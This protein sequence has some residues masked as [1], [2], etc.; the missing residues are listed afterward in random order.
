MKYKIRVLL[1]SSSAQTFFHLIPD[2]KRSRIIRMFLQKEYQLP[3]DLKEFIVT[4][5]EQTGFDVFLNESSLNQLDSLVEE[6]RRF[7][8]TEEPGYKVTRS[9]IMQHVISQINK[10]HQEHPIENTKGA[11]KP[12]YLPRSH[13]EML[14]NMIS[15]REITHTIEDFIYEEYK[16]P[17]VTT[18]MLKAKQDEEMVITQ[19]KLEEKAI[20]LLDKFAKEK[21][22]TRSH[23]LRDVVDQLIKKM[24]S[25]HGDVSEMVYSRLDDIVTELKGFANEDQ[26]LEAIQQYQ[27]EKKK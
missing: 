19:L 26:I 22:V 6:V 2:R 8:E 1:T 21:K 23:I 15:S 16:G 14:L 17:I 9:T 27:I 20:D 7:L 11:M 25:E 13:K 5:E 10:K 3:K 12:F 4:E 24:K 18:E